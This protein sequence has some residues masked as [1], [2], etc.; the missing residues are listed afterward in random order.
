[1]SNEQVFGILITTVSGGIAFGVWQGS[2]AAG[3]FMFC[4]LVAVF[5][6]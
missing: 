6:T 4:A 5:Q 1:M 3:I 2:I